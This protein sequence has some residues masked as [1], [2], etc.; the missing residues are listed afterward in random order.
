MTHSASIEYWRDL[1]MWVKG[2][3]RSLKMATLD[4]SYTSSYGTRSQ[5]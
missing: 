4:R 5:L 2:R 1:K 3:S